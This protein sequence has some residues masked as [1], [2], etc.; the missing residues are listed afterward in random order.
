MSVFDE[1]E[2]QWG[3]A[4]LPGT[5][6]TEAEKTTITNEQAALKAETYITRTPSTTLTGEQALSTLAT[7]LLKVT[8]GTGIL[9]TAAATDLPGHAHAAPGN[10][11]IVIDG[12]GSVI[13]PGVKLDLRMPWALTWTG[14]NAFADQVGA[15][16]VDLWRDIY[17][18]YPPTNADS[19]TGTT[20]IVIPSGNNKW[21]V[22]PLGGGMDGWDLT[23]DAGDLIR[24]NV[25]S[26]TTITRVTIEL[27]YTRN[28][29]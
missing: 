6:I 24:V 16:Q 27:T 4:G 15:M 5:G 13:P 9:T 23:M 17:G 18:N 22:T 20:P 12:A 28:I 25:D 8:N 1:S 11:Q 14:W 26:C 2:V 7:G 21:G 3:Q 19:I 10:I 29:Q